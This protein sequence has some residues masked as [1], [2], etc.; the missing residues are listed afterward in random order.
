MAVGATIGATMGEA[1]IT[2]FGDEVG[3]EDVTGS[4]TGA[5]DGLGGTPHSPHVALQISNAG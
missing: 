2:R 5:K 3:S 4:G 1:L